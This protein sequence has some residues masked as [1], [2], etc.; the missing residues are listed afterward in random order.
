[1]YQCTYH[2]KGTKEFT[3]V[4]HTFSSEHPGRKADMLIQIFSNITDQK[5]INE[6]L[7]ILL[8]AFPEAEIAGI[9]AAAGYSQ[10]SLTTEE[11]VI[12]FLVFEQSI[13]QTLRWEV[14]D[15]NIYAAGRDCLTRC[16]NVPD[17]K[18]VEILSAQNSPNPEFFINPL[19]EL[20]ESISV[21]GGVAT[22]IDPEDTPVVFDK[23]GILESGIVAVL[24]SGG[25]TIECRTS[26][27][28]HPLGLPMHITGLSD[29]C[30]T[31]ISLN[32]KPA[33]DIYRK[34]LRLDPS[35]IGSSSEQLLSFPLIV[36]R[37]GIDFARVPDYFNEDGSIVFPTV[38]ETG[39]IVRLG[40]G[41]PVDI[42]TESSKIARHLKNAS[43]EGMMGF[44]CML[45]SRF[46]KENLVRLMK[47]Y[48]AFLSFCGGLVHGEIGRV[49]G[50]VM[51]FQ[52]SVVLTV[53]REKT[54]ADIED[55]GQQKNDDGENL[56]ISIPEYDSPY[57]SLL[58]TLV[59]ETTRELNK[60]QDQLRYMAAHDGLTGL[61][62]RGVL[63]KRLKEW[64]Q[65]QDRDQS[66]L[67]AIMLDLDNFKDVNDNYG[68]D[69]GYQVLITAAGLL[70][71]N[72]RSDDTVCRW[73]GE[74]FI[75]LLPDQTPRDAFNTAERLRKSIEAEIILPNGKSVTGSFGVTMLYP[76]DDLQSFYR[77]VDTAM[78]AAKN[79]GR[80][81]TCLVDA[82]NVQYFTA[83]NLEADN[84]AKG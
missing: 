11:S 57:S 81:R 6:N 77:R 48:A 58:A 2:V 5:R 15:K 36:T 19:S 20:P 52:L 40:Y 13:I 79:S 29:D 66:S 78:Y 26:L 14:S 68:H 75:L 49:N 35:E 76:F 80:N 30:H 17:L 56:Q 18:A 43:I 4:I 70:T 38:F 74:E 46:L 16:L 84:C 54:S 62:N 44:T 37:K 12:S 50:R 8:D 21:F 25:I 39:D 73:G 9:S 69:V 28:W 60:V 42:L 3:D 24:Y 45:R 32:D 31:L 82:R 65:F 72:L 55:A 63:E 33:A 71:E 51:L 53:F 10:K 27:G 47:N 1:M 22:S 41:D 7:Q 34:Y 61:Y 83:D 64:M 67:A 23:N 59:T